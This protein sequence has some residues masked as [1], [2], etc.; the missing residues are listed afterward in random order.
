MSGSTDISQLMHIC[1]AT[2]GRRVWLIYDLLTFSFERDTK[3]FESL[4]EK[5]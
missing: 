3:P 4:N 5:T 1:I 2:Y